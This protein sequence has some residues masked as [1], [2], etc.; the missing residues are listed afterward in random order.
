MCIICTE[1]QKGKLTFT[2]ALSNLKELTLDDTLTDENKKHLW[3]IEQKIKLDDFEKKW[4]NRSK[5]KKGD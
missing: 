4:V 5:E 1:W 2:E 3:E